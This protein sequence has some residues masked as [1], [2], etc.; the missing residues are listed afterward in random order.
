MADLWI[1]QPVLVLPDLT[2][3]FDILLHIEDWDVY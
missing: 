2:K 3:N 1:T